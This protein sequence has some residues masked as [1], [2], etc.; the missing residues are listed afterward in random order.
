MQ[1]NHL[2]PDMSDQQRKLHSHKGLP[3]GSQ[4]EPGCAFLLSTILLGN[5]ALETPYR[6]IHYFPNVMSY[7]S[8]FLNTA[9]IFHDSETPLTVFQTPKD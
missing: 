8:T 3:Y 1:V 7:Q 2:N 5:G 9:D 6:L 4:M